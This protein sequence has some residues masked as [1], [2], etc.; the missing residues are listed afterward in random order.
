M[1]QAVRASEEIFF[2][3]IAGQPVDVDGTPALGVVGERSAVE[4]PWTRPH[5]RLVEGPSSRSSKCRFA[6]PL[7]EPDFK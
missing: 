4:R 6:N 3:L 7:P 5:G 2:A 1:E